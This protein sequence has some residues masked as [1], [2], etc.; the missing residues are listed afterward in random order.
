M[1]E[2]T[3]A[4]TPKPEAGKDEPKPSPGET[5][6]PETGLSTEAIAELQSRIDAQQAELDKYRKKAEQ[7]EGRAK[8]AEALL[9][10]EKTEVAEQVDTLSQQLEIARQ[11]QE[12]L[13]SQVAKLT[14]T[15]VGS[16]VNNAVLGVAGNLADGAAG[17]LAS[18][19]SSH[20]GVRDGRVVVLT[21]NGTPR[22]GNSGKE[23]SAAELRDE[24]LKTRPYFLKSKVAPGTGGSSDTSGSIGVMKSVSEIAAMADHEATAYLA[25]LTPEQRQ[26]VYSQ[27]PK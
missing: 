1:I 15:Q 6:K 2:E 17:D 5:P 9:K 8:K 19:M 27:A 20:M 23:M 11:Q 10:S 14:H 24:L 3:G 12:E 18:L 25:T 4:G 21:E 22:I 26:Y 7:Q 13:V 16:T